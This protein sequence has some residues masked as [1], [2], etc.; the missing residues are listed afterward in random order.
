MNIT[1][2]KDTTTHINPRATLRRC[3]RCGENP[4]RFV[5]GIGMRVERI[6][7]LC[8]VECDL[9][10]LPD[11]MARR[12]QEALIRWITTPNPELDCDD[13]TFAAQSADDDAMTERWARQRYVASLCGEVAA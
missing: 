9:T 2:T 13:E 7:P 11:P 1:Y 12:L 10:T 3:D 8:A 6:C 4:P 5:I